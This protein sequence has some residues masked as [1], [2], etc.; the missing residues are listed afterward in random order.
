MQE[1]LMLLAAALVS[2]SLYKTAALDLP[3]GTH[4][5]A[6]M[7][8]QGLA[9]DAAAAARGLLLSTLGPG[10]GQGLGG[11]KCLSFDVATTPPDASQC[12]A[13][14]LTISGTVNAT[15][16]GALCPQ[17][18][19]TWTEA[20]GRSTI[21]SSAL[22]VIWRDTVLKKGA[23]LYREPLLKS[24]ETKFDWPDTKV[25]I[26]GYRYQEARTFALI[27]LPNGESH[28]VLKGDLATFDQTTP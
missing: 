22:D 10:T 7:A 4:F 13:F 24:L 26:G 5:A 19:G 8:A 16:D 14:H 25:Q 2:M 15:V 20:G 28:Y 27:R 1:V 18:G 12:R 11:Y 3:A 21:N 6:A 9:P 17:P 23:S